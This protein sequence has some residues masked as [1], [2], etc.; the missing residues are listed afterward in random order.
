MRAL[1]AELRPAGPVPNGLVPAL[2]K[3]LQR[4]ADRERL[5]IALE[6]PGYHARHPDH[7]E[8][9]YRVVQESLNN[10]VKHAQAH[11]VR[12][13]LWQAGGALELAVADDGNGYDPA[14]PATSGLG[15]TGMRERVERFGGTLTVESVP[16]AGTTVR[17]RLPD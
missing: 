14:A 7:E 3:H 17:V 8:A 9:L 15:L 12:V 16:G 13:A 11:R 4:V 6:A 5:E 2:E 10:I 1:L